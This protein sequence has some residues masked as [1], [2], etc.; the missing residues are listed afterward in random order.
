MPKMKTNRA[1]AKRFR[2][3]GGGRIRRAKA[4]LSHGMFN[5]TRKHRRRLRDNDMV[6]DCMGRRV[7]RLLP[8]G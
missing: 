3:T 8:Y 7:K 1:A 2:R 6:D 5:K 4:G